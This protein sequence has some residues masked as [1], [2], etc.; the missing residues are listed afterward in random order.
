MDA[1]HIST[2][3]ET[4]GSKYKRVIEVMVQDSDL[5]VGHPEVQVVL[6]RMEQVLFSL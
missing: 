4:C 3:T 1:N 2:D 5:M 6:M